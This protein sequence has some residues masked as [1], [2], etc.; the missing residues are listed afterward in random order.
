MEEKNLRLLKVEIPLHLEGEGGFSCRG[1]HWT[2]K[3]L[4]KASSDL[5]D[6]DL[7]LCGITMDYNPWTLSIFTSVLYHIKRI[8]DADLNYPILLDPTGT[9]IDGWHRIAKAILKGDLT[10]TA[11]RLKVMPEVDSTYDD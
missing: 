5:E 1:N 7:P 2:D 10:I 6:F 3:T 9:I 8:E 4:R 11:R